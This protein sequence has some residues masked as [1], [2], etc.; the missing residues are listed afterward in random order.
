MYW[1]FW[2]NKYERKLCL[3]WMVSLQLSACSQ[4]I[5]PS[6]TWV[7]GIYLNFQKQK[8]LKNNIC[9]ILNPNLIK[10]NS[11]KSSHQDFPRTPKAH[12]N[13]SEFYSYDLIWFW[14]KKSFNTQE[15]LHCKSQC[16]GTKP[17]DPFLSRAFW[18]DK[19]CDL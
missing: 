12:S 15:L 18:R 3:N 5:F 6:K 10:I 2:T 11:I 14:V 17:M 8:W 7:F 16:H 9:H 1:F 4:L 19:E 13:S